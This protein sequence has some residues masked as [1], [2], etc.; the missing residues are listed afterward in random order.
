MT[1]PLAVILLLTLGTWNLTQAQSDS[2]A[3]ERGR[4]IAVEQHRRESGFGDTTVDIRMVLTGADGRVRD[5]RLTWSTLEVPGDADGDKSLTVFHEPRD[6][7]GTAFLSVTHIGRPDDQWLYL[8]SLKRVK[9]ISSANQS[10]SFMGSEFSYEDLLSDEVA[11]FDYRWLRDEPCTL[12]ECFVLERRPKYRDSG[13]SR[14]VLW[15]D[16][17]S[18]RTVR[19]EYYDRDG[20]LEKTLS[21]DD[22]RQYLDR[23]WRA[24]R[25]TMVN[26][27][28]GKR[29]LLQFS[30]FQFRSGLTDQ[31]FDPGAL[32]RVR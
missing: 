12:G 27:Q 32:A 2:S 21:L 15:L 6:I 3:A 28:T 10:G 30:A 17:D 26:H 1:R 19:T 9:R 18:Y 16:K 4:E 5:R 31:D 8:P 25:L 20:K 11:R 13:Y 7:A 23:F 29:T 22:Y 14:E 24:Q